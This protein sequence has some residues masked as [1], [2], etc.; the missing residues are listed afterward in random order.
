ML[1]GKKILLGVTGSIAAYKAALL[2]RLLKKEEAEVQVV[3]TAS[4]SSFITPLTLATLSEKPVLSEFVK[5]KTG[6]WNNHVELGLWADVLLIAPASANTLAKMASGLCDNLLTAVYL[7]ARCPVFV[8]PAMDLDMYAHPST[9]ANLQKLGQWGNRVIDATTGQ[10]ASGLHGKGRMSEPAD[11][12]EVLKQHFTGKQL[13]KG[14]KVLVTAGPTQE[15]IDPVRYI[16]NGSSGKMGYA[17]AE[18][19]HHAGAEVTLV[20]GPVQVRLNASGIRLLEVT[21]AEEM[22]RATG[23]HYEN[24]HIA[25][26]TA[27]VSDYTPSVTSE[28]K[29]KKSTPTLQINLK[30]SPDIALE[31]GKRKKPG[32][33]NVG[34]ALETDN[35]L[36]NARKKL[37]VKHMDLIVLNSLRDQG[38]GFGHDTNLVTFIDARKQRRTELK[39]K[40][41]LAVE[42]VEEIALRFNK[43]KA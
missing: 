42:I 40:Q 25:I 43:L 38:A 8:A 14:K 16:S 20:S 23:E 13:L 28:I 30:K 32:Q 4:A 15:F 36:L 31:M 22:Y 39:T 26:F 11:I 41:Q 19:M 37:K 10:L 2:T 27:A 9:T 1:K 17:I 35:E 12:V 24:S 6:S 7:S 5:D 3:M 18:A 21:T 34:F 33:M 29:L